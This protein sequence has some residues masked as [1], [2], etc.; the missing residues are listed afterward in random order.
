[1]NQV[2]QDKKDIFRRSEIDSEAHIDFS[3]IVKR[4][5]WGE[6]ARMCE[7]AVLLFASVCA[8]EPDKDGEGASSPVPM[9]AGV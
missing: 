3:I 2:N 1:M 5:C 8:W 4:K 9:A 6:L 7:F